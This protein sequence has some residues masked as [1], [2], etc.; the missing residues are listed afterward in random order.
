VQVPLGDFALLGISLQYEL[1][2]TNVLNLLD[3][4][5]IPLKASDRGEDD[6]VVVGGGHAAFNAEPMADFFDA[7]VVG[8]GEEL[9]PLVVDEIKAWKQGFGDRAPLLRR[10]AKLEGVYVPQGYDLVPNASGLL[11]PRAK[12]GWPA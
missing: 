1:H 11:C 9:T 7:F 5:G 10:L 4:G 2:Y 8:D 12:D 6:P 3:L